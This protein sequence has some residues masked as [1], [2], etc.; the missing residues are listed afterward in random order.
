MTQA[1]LK[2]IAEVAGCSRSVVSS[3]LNKSKGNTRVS[4]ELRQRI[5][6]TAEGLNYR[7]NFAARSLTQRT[8]RTIGFYVMPWARN[9]S[10]SHPYEN[11][12]LCGVEKSCR[13]KQYSLLVLNLS[14]Q[15][16]PELCLQ[17]L[18]EHRVDGLVVVQITNSN[19]SLALLSKVPQLVVI[20]AHAGAVGVPRVTFDNIGCIELAVNHLI[21]LGHQRIGYIGACHA[22][23]VA[24]ADERRESFIASM[25]RQGLPIA[26]GSVFD[27]PDQ[28]AGARRELCYERNGR[29]GAEAFLA[30]KE[31]RPTALVA[32]NDLTAAGA[33]RYLQEKGMKLPAEMSVIGI[34]DSDFCPLLMPQLTSVQQPLE[35]MG[36]H[37]A[38]MLIERACSGGVVESEAEE[39]IHQL[40]IARPTLVIRK[41]TARCEH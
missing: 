3:V 8:T 30:M 28:S 5:L 35:E 12:L 37:A 40:Y 18:Q 39:K 9:T 23:S 24:D 10:I 31:N 36:R 22:C 6:T 17:Q 11:G 33:M 14:G 13:D 38:S 2:Q 7:P 19:E 4:E 27:Q 16:P 15:E 41:S 34:D 25:R 32:F 21:S 20:S 29:C 1:T 26:N